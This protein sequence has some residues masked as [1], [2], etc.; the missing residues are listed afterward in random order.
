MAAGAPVAVCRVGARRDGACG[1]ESSV[2]AEVAGR[3]EPEAQ[4]ERKKG[5]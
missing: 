4:R 3:G 5:T 1:R 2:P